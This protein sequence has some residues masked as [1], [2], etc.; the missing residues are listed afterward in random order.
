M[1]NSRGNNVSSIDVNWGITLLREG[2][3]DFYIR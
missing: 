2:F 1:K 3:G